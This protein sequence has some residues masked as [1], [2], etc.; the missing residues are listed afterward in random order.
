[1]KKV[2]MITFVLLLGISSNSKAQAAGSDVLEGGKVVLEFVKLFSS[3]KDKNTKRP[4][5]GDCKKDKASD[6]C[7]VNK[8]TAAIKILVEDRLDSSK[9]YELIVQPGLIENLL[10][11]PASIYNCTIIDFTSNVVL[12]K[13]DIRLEKCENPTIEIN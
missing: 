1:M 5:I 4:S 12:R 9:K 7:Y 11:I 2:L 10:H 13:G 6:I 3:D 8:R